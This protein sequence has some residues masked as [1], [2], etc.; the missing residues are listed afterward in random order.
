M[1]TKAKQFDALW[2]GILDNAGLPVSGG[3]VYTYIAGSSSTTKA[4]YNDR[5]KLSTASNPLILDSYGRAEVYGDGLYNIIVKDSSGVTLWDMDNIEIIATN[6]NLY[7]D[8]DTLTSSSANGDIKIVPTGSGIIKVGP[9]SGDAKIS[10]NQTNQDLNL[11]PDGTGLVYL[12]KADTGSTGVNVVL[13]EDTMVSDRA[14]ALATQQST[15]AYTDNSITSLRTELSAI[16]QNNQLTSFAEAASTDGYQAYL[17]AGGVGSL[18]T[19]LLAT[20]T[21]FV[22]KASGISKTVSTNQTVSITSGYGSNN[23]LLIN[24]P[25]WTAASSQETAS[26]VFGEK[27]HISVIMNYDTAGTNISGL[28]VGDKVVFRGVNSSAA[29]EYIYC[30]MVTVG[31]SGTLRILWRAI[32]STGTRI[33][34]RDNDTWTICRTNWIFCSTTNG[35]LVATIVHP[36][37]VD[38]LP[39]AGIAN[40]Y[41][42]LKSTGQWYLDNGSSISS[43]E[44]G[45]I[46][47]SFSHNTSDNGAVAYFPEWGHFNNKFLSM[48]RSDVQ[49]TIAIDNLSTSKGLIINGTLQIADKIYKYKNTRVNTATSGD[50]ESGTNDISAVGIKNIYVSYSTGKINLSDIQPREWDDGIHMHPF[51]MWRWIGFAL[52]SASAFYYFTWGNNV[53]NIYAA[54]VSDISWTN[55]LANYPLFSGYVPSFLKL[56]NIAVNCGAAASPSRSAEYFTS[57]TSAIILGNNNAQMQSGYFPLYSG[58]I[59]VVDS[60]NTGQVRPSL[61]CEFKI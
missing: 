19:T 30:E 43:T 54:G 34:F 35:S 6:A 27:S 31:A 2:S 14:D 20:T 15:K 24:E 58:Y 55:V 33:T 47:A 18:T 46:G 29:V 48:K 4:T 7:L 39:S 16:A 59:R 12:N 5:D 45:L 44:Y 38:T 1:S 52:H 25:S 56:L 3:F 22:F 9:A 17:S 36:I 60:T 50:R 28:S 53:V 10:T 61:Y 26:K 8:T 57:S 32:D 42:L 11:A 13:D 51:K 41:I 21:P 23:T 40:R 49:T 37:E